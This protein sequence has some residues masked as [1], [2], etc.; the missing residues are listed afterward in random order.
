MTEPINALLAVP[1]RLAAR[2]LSV[3]EPT[4]RKL[5]IPRVRI[6]STGIRYRVAD[7]DEWLIQNREHME[8]TEEQPIHE[9]E[10]TK[11]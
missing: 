4:L 11:A 6:G 5:K 1:P 9:S 10:S 2:M 8:N 7:L 3:S